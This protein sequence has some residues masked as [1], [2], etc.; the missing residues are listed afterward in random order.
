MVRMTSFDADLVR[1]WFDRV[2]DEP[3]MPHWGIVPT[4]QER[5]ALAFVHHARPALEAEDG[6]EPDPVKVHII[7]H[8]AAFRNADM[9]NNKCA[10]VALGK[11]IPIAHAG[12]A[13]F[14]DG[15]A[16]SAGQCQRL[17]R[18]RDRH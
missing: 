1:R 3:V 12:A 9:R 14:P 17:L 2:L 6:L 11:Q 10:A 5:F 13:R 7:G 18:C 16:G 8:L 15:F 4:E